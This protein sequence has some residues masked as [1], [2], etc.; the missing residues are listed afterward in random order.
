MTLL[1]MLSPLQYQSRPGST[2]FRPH[3]SSMY[4]L[5]SQILSNKCLCELSPGASSFFCCRHPWL[6]GTHWHFL[7]E[8]F[9]KGHFLY[10][11]TFPREPH[12][13]PLTSYGLYL[14][15]TFTWKLSLVILFKIKPRNGWLARWIKNPAGTPTSHI[16]VCRAQILTMLQSP[17][18]C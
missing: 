3:Q 10:L 13:C 15:T 9:F 12:A 6:P 16:G 11:G 7:P 18:S 8:R 17:A 2:E 4:R 1:W 5:K 14:S